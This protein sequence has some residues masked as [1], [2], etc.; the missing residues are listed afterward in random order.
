MKFR[1]FMRLILDG[2]YGLAC[3]APRC[4]IFSSDRNDLFYVHRNEP[5]EN[6]VFCGYRFPSKVVA[7]LF[8]DDE[9][10]IVL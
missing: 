2:F 9:F 8:I 3:S 1:L 7:L 5:R 10:F 4:K 6:G